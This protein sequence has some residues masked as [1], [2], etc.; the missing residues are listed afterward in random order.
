MKQQTIKEALEN[1]YKNKAKG[2]VLSTK[3]DFRWSFDF[4]QDDYAIDNRG[5]LFIFEY[6][7]DGAPL[8]RGNF[9]P[10]EITAIKVEHTYV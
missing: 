9:K 1:A 10:D 2:A 7:K 8:G 4:A 5:T 6:S 3:Y